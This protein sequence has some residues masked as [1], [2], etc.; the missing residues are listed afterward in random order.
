MTEAEEDGPKSP[1]P[2]DDGVRES[3]LAAD[4]RGRPSLP[5]HTVCCWMP[6]NVGPPFQHALF[7]H[8][9]HLPTMVGDDAI[10]QKYKARYFNAIDKISIIFLGNPCFKFKCA[11]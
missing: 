2:I 4:G 3:R 9:I 6:T 1:M 10:G 7:L 11:L 5:S 8:P